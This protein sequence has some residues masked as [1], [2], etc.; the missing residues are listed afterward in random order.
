[1]I[2]CQRIK[3]TTSRRPHKASFY[4]VVFRGFRWSANDCRWSPTSRRLIVR[5]METGSARGF[6]CCNENLSPTKLFWQA[7][8]DWSAIIDK[9]LPT[10]DNLR[11][12]PKKGGCQKAATGCGYS[13]RYIMENVTQVASWF[14]PSTLL[15]ARKCL[16]QRTTTYIHAYIYSYIHKCIHPYTYIHTHISTTCNSISVTIWLGC[17]LCVCVCVCM[18]VRVWMY[19][20]MSASVP[21]LCV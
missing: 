7:I 14:N 1:M 13:K 20:C 5:T 17:M 9:H 4:L 19:V 21:L 3:S 10:S 12:P 8:A 11:Q 6:R 2:G 18:K 16:H 15:R